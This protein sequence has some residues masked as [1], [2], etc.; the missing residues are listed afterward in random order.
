MSGPLIRRRS[1]PSS[2]RY[3]ADKLNEPLS[4]AERAGVALTLNS[5]ADEI[6][7]PKIPCTCTDT[8]RSRIDYCPMP[9]EREYGACP[10]QRSAGP[11]NNEETSP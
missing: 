4:D 5:L 10:K 2:L 1:L 11:A 7:P 3:L 9:H 6:D 8:V